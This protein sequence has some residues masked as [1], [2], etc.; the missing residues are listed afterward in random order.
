M[1]S[2]LVVIVAFVAL[3][4]W[5]VEG[6]QPKSPERSARTGGWVM[7][8]TADGRPDLEGVWENN[9][10]TPLE[11]PRQ[12]ADK[13]RLS[14]EEL[15]S[16]ERRAR[17]LTDSGVGAGRRPSAGSSISDVRCSKKRSGSQ[18]WL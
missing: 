6:Q 2:T 13:A 10:A 1:R 16:M 14:D 17:T 3:S 12:L 4:S 15:T 9:S 18:F 7:P 5:N 8:R 11:R